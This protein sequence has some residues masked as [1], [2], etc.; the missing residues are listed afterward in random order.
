MTRRS[1]WILAVLLLMQLAA[2]MTVIAPARAGASSMSF[3]SEPSFSSRS[4]H[5]GYFVINGEPGKVVS[6]SIQ[7]RNISQT[8]IV[9]QLAPVAALTALR[10]GVDYGLPGDDPGVGSWIRLSTRK[11]SLGAGTSRNVPFTIS[12]PDT[13]PA[14]V[15]LAGIA[16]WIAPNEEMTSPVAQDQDGAFLSVQTRRV[17]AVQIDLPGGAVAKLDVGSVD[18]VALPDGSY[19]EIHLNNSGSALTSG[20][21][22][23]SVPD[24]GF[25]E[26]FTFGTFVPGT[27][28]RYPIKLGTAPDDGDYAVRVHLEFDGGRTDWEGRLV[29]RSALIDILIDRGAA[30]APFEFPFRLLGASVVLASIFLV[31]IRRWTRVGQ[32]RRS[33]S[34]SKV[35]AKATQSLPVRLIPS[36]IPPP[37]PPA[38]LTPSTIPPPPPARLTQS[39]T[40]SG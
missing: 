34:L 16:A 11:V 12:I 36:S 39:M 29:I 15:N 13:A 20:T 27:A 35:S 25:Q 17:I 31:L 26:D 21:G 33:L 28:M 9:V 30:E 14:G 5:D 19:L 24:L 40:A 1:P 3:T 38:R 8:P 2:Q 6:D 10:G 7:V 22:T 23:L 32:R 18:A 4:E 37:P